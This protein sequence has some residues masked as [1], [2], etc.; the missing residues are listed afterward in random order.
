MARSAA[1]IA[2]NYIDAWNRHDAAAILA[3]FA[4]GG[5]YSDPATK[6]LLS[7]SAIVAYAE[8]LWA[9]FPDLSFDVVSLLDQGA[10]LVC[11]EWMMKGTNTGAFQGLPPTG[12]AVILPGADFIRLDGERIRSVQGYFD[13][14]ALPRALGFDV[15]VQPKSIGPF[16]F[17]TSTRLASGSTVTPGAFSITWI[18][19]RDDEER[20][21]IAESARK[22]AAEMLDMPGF[23]SWVGATV[24]DRMM[25]ITA[26]E[27]P[28]A[29]APLMGG[30]EH[31]SVVKRFFSPE[32]ARGGA[33]GVWLPL[34]LNPRWV[35]CTVCCK[36]VDAGKTDGRCKC[37]AALPTEPP[38]W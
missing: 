19:A 24:D 3:H 36:M 5:T 27:S 18:E 33:T 22:I 32:L 15:V 2:R 8:A 11:A 6:G 37:G 26:W 4:V 9:A 38:Y 21:K 13:G 28:E 1:Q 30:G 29:A 20:R 14:A 34:R 25:T 7:G 10:D 35:R 16:A 23:I 31:L 17:G 12:I